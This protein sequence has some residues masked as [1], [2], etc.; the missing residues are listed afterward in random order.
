MEQSLS[1]IAGFFDGEGCVSVNSNGS[2]QIRVINT[3]CAVLEYFVEVLG[4]AVKS[5]KQIVNKPQYHWSVY[6]DDAYR[7]AEALA[8]LCIEKRPQL[9]KM[10]EWRDERGNFLAT[11][12]VGGR[13][14]VA[15]PDRAG[16]IKQYQKEL[17][18][19]KMA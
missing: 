15:H 1:Y 8:P 19:M 7:V 13:G 11:Q 14:H 18:E 16:R 12:K 4:G 6:G 5:R 17:T 10:L 3:S 9:L 2:I